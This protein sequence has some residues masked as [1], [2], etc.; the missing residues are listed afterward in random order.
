VF[1]VICRAIELRFITLILR[2]MTSTEKESP[3]VGPG[4]RSRDRGVGIPVGNIEVLLF[5]L[6]YRVVRDVYRI[7][8]DWLTGRSRH[9]DA[10]K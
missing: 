6:P 3:A 9:R 4:S 10:S 1:P 7:R 5:D 8:A 2:T